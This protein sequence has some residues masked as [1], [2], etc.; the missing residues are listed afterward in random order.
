MYRITYEQSEEWIEFMRNTQ[1]DMDDWVDD[2]VGA[3]L[4]RKSAQLKWIDGRDVGI[5]E[6]DHNAATRQAMFE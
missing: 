4:I 2:I 3:D 1:A 5:A 6:N